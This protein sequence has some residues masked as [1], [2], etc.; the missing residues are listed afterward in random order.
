MITIPINNENINKMKIVKYKIRLVGCM[1]RKNI[2]LLQ[3]EQLIM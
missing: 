1:W 3:S 2:R